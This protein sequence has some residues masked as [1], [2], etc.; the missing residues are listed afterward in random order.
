MKQVFDGGELHTSGDFHETCA[1]DQSDKEQPPRFGAMQVI[2]DDH[3]AH[4]QAAEG[5]SE[6]QQDRREE[7]ARE[8]TGDWYRTIERGATPR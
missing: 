8:Y 1:Q 4:A 5:E 6:V 3:H 2:L 7:H